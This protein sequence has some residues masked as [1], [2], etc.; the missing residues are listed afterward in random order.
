MSFDRL[1]MDVG[2]LCFG[3]LGLRDIIR[4]LGELIRSL[5]DLL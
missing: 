5:L 3:L 1:I 2:C 4:W